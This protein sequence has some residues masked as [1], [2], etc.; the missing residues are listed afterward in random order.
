MKVE[1]LT[2]EYT[3]S[4]QN[5]VYTLD[6]GIIKRS[7]PVT[8]KLRF[9]EVDSAKFNVSETCGCTSIGNTI[10]D[11]TTFESTIKYN[12]ADKNISKTVVILNGSNR[13]E[14]KLIGTTV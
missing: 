11:S 2:E 6:F 14:L 8:S 7:I 3:L 9:T 5:G 4:E 12:A 13:T 1:K 10:I